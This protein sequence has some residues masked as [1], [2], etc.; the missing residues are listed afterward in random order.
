[1]DRAGDLY[2]FLSFTGRGEN[3]DVGRSFGL[4]SLDRL[5]WRFVTE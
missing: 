5:D 2:G 1:M 3:R 4:D